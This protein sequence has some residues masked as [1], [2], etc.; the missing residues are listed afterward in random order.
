MS[1]IVIFIGCDIIF[2]IGLAPKIYATPVFVS[3]K[4]A[5]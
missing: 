5:E 4:S 1:H 2:G 3:S